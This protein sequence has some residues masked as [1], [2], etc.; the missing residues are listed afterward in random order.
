[1]KEKKKTDIVQV[2]LGDVFGIEDTCY[3]GRCSHRR[4]SHR[5]VAIFD[6]I[7]YVSVAYFLRLVDAIRCL[8]Q[9][10][11]RLLRG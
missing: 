11:R 3:R 6:P 10:F 2:H 8:R 4:V 1:M 5:T 7:A 9:I